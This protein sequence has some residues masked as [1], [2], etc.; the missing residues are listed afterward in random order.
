MKTRLSV[1]D[2]L[3]KLYHP[4]LVEESIC[5]VNLF[6][7]GSHGPDMREGKLDEHPIHLEGVSTEVFDMFVQFKFGCPCPCEAYMNKDLKDFLEFTQKFQCS[8]FTHDFLIHIG[9]NYKI[10][11]I[12]TLGFNQLVPTPWTDIENTHRDFMGSEVFTMLVYVKALLDEHCH[13][14]AAEPPMMRHAPNCLDKKAC[15]EDW[16]VV[17]WNSTGQLLLDA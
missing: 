8:S 5:F 3:Y 16:W 15:A 13:I 10:P 9:I 12:F 14:V 17:W 7:A 1:E 4:V 11:D 2:T 6:D